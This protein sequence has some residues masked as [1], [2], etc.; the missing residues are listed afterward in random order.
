[1]PPNFGTSAT[2]DTTRAL[3]AN[4]PVPGGKARP[5]PRPKKRP[6]PKGKG[7]RG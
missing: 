7:R 3:Y 6:R 4:Q 1:M 2:P 5:K